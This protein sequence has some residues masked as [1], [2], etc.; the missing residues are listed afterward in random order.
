MTRQLRLFFRLIAAFALSMPLA[1]QAHAGHV[2]AEE[3]GLVIGLL[4]AAVVLLTRAATT[5]VSKRSTE[6]GRRSR[7]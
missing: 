2:H 5:R 6:A 4:V 1:A 3:W 7:T